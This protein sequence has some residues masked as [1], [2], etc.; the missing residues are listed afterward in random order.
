MTCFYHCSTPADINECLEGSHNCHKDANC[1]NNV[2][3]FTCDCKDGFN[4]NGTYCYGKS[5][6]NVDVCSR[7][8]IDQMH[9]RKTSKF[10]RSVHVE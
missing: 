7:I 8:A 4:G 3:S 9:W 10:F 5:T 1:V 6:P 2:G